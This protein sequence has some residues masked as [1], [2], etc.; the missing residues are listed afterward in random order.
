MPKW[1]FV[2]CNAGH[3]R[4]SGAAG[5]PLEVASCSLDWRPLGARIWPLADPKD[6]PQIRALFGSLT[7]RKRMERRESNSGG[8]FSAS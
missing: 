7:G 8:A 4:S 5:V 2:A 1:R 3:W 6:W